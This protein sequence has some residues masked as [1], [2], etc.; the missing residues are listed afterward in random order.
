MTIDTI[1][2][3]QLATNCYLVGDP[4][5]REA[6]I[7]DPGAEPETILKRVRGGEWAVNYITI[8]HGHFDHVLAAGPLVRELKAPFLVPP[9]DLPIL[10]HAHESASSWTGTPGDPIPLHDGV[11]E[12]AGTITVGAY[13][14]TVAETPGHSP[15]GICLIGEMHAFVGDTVFAGSVGRTDFPGGDFPTLMQ[16]IREKI[17][18]LDDDVVLY[19]GHGPATTVGEER[20]TNPFILQ[21]DELAGMHG[22]VL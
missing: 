14:F 20:M 4:E 19:T 8:T 13:T 7:V 3:G 5:T 22:S 9:K 11:L 1:P 17:L 21:M 6:C 12:E 18:V 2:V 15:G 16:S 10:K